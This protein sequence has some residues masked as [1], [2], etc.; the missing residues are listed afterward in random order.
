MRQARPLDG[1]STWHHGLELAWRALLRFLGG[2]TPSRARAMTPSVAG[3]A[4]SCFA[5]DLDRRPMPAP[6]LAE[7]GVEAVVGDLG[8]SHWA[9]QSGSSRLAATWA[10]VMSCS[11]RPWP[12]ELR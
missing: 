2:M 1:T 3:A 8:S 6:P 10:G 4:F 9:I 12:R 7:Q 11:P 5:V